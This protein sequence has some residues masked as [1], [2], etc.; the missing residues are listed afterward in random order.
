MNE[1]EYAHLVAALELLESYM[2]YYGCQ[3]QDY[4]TLGNAQEVLNGNTKQ[5]D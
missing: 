1:K 5:G 2:K 3:M 4:K